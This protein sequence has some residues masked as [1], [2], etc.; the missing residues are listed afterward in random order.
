[1]RPSLVVTKSRPRRRGRRLCVATAPIGLAER[2]SRCSPSNHG[3][4]TKPVS[5]A[6]NLAKDVAVVELRVLGALEINASGG[7]EVE[8]LA[9]QAK[10]AALLAYLAAATPR[11]LHRRDKLL[12]L[13]WP[14]LDHARARAALNQAVYVLRATLGED[15]LVSHGDGALGLADAVWCDAVAFAAALDVGRP[16]D[17]LKLYRGD[18]LEGFFISGAPEFEHWMDGER[19]R[20]RLRASDGAWAL[21]EA[22]ATAGDPFEAA[23]W[24][25]WAA[26]RR[27]A[28]E[29]VIRRLMTFLHGLGDRAAATRVYQDLVERLAQEFELQPSA[30]TEAL[31]ASI[32]QEE[33]APA[34][35]LVGPASTPPPAALLPGKKLPLRRAVASVAVVAGL[36]AG[37]VFW[38]S[39]REQSRDSLVRFTLEFPAGQG[40]ARIAGATIALSADGS[41]LAYV[42][43]GP[44]GTELFLRSMDQVGARPIAH[45]RDAQTPFFSPD[46]EWL[47]FVI[48]DAIRKVP[49]AGGPA[50]TVCNVTTNVVGASW[51][52]GPNDVIVFATP[53]GLWQVPASGG[54]A[55]ILAL[56]DT[57]RGGRYRWPDVLP[58][59]RGAVFTL[60]DDSGFHLA[61][62]S[63]ATGAVHSLDLEGTSPR[64]VA[65][66]YLLFART[67]GA[68]LAAAFDQDAMR[69]TGPAIPVAD[70]VLVGSAGVAK[71]GASRAGVLAYVPWA[72]AERT[73]ELVDR[74]GHAD[75]VPVPRQGFN[76]AR[77]SPD[78]RRVITDVLPPDAD[79]PDIWELD[80][81]ANTFRRVTFDSGSLS[82]VWSADGRRIAFANKPGGRPFGYAIRWIP[83]DGSDSAETLLPFAFGQFPVAFTPDG[84]ALLLQIRHP[85]SGFDI[86]TLPLQGER[87]LRP[88][89]RGPSEEHSPAMSPDGRWLAY[90]SN[91]SGQD[92]VYV[93]PF[94][95]PGTPV[96]ISS[97]GGREPRWASSGREIFYRGERG[98]VAAAVTTSPSFRVGERLVLFND[99]QYL[100]HPYGAAYDVHPDGR[101]FLM[102]RRGL[103]SPEVVV[104][105][106]WFGRQHLA[107]EHFR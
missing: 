107:G 89:L 55:R 99:K 11:G 69:I 13:F 25:R 52:G 43:S 26:D 75:T 102:I 87:T 50:I 66:G 24:A 97:G 51:G 78:G 56:S 59:G 74:T 36:A 71:L 48:E 81:T 16:A 19:E 92:E 62:V 61:A 35:R 103:E 88:Y 86:W 93:R 79:R 90:V 104:V 46:G 1:M 47:G 98:M 94:P 77:F 20:L 72:S 9:H 85:G 15:A 45:T 42:G 91:E 33:R 7:R 60:V 31:A 40:V 12:A 58:N 82:P 80:L 41:D 53:A 65:P 101:R 76:S 100:A 27:P 29:M 54:V 3:A 70:G 8:P 18:L 49:L 21:A 4:L 23:R 38:L 67:D 83:T 28:D 68:L 22:A 2:R 32:R 57:A 105:L 5:A 95:R 64:F 39:G 6:R 34:R 84:R 63:L 30:E 106:N 44:K 14:E 17:A 10:R 73:L 37:A 96:L